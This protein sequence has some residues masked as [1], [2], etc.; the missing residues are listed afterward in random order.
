M[1]TRREQIRKAVTNK[2]WQTFRLS[3]K[4][5]PTAEK[6]ALLEEYYHWGLINGHPREMVDIRIDN[7]IKAL[8]RGGQLYPGESLQ[9]ALDSNWELRI[10]R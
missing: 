4:G 2:G 1:Q 10:K 8:C 5:K 9:T 6:L 3:L 7:Y